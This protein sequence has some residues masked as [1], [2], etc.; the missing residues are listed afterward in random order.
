MLA[1]SNLTGQ[2]GGGR[3]IVGLA[4]SL[5][6]RLMGSWRRPLPWFE[7]TIGG[8]AAMLCKRLVTAARARSVALAGSSRLATA[9][10]PVIST[11]RTVGVSPSGFSAISAVGRTI[12]VGVATQP[13]GGVRN[14]TFSAARRLTRPSTTICWPSNSALRQSSRASAA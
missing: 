13:S 3:S 4:I 9:S 12:W 6:A 7:G 5:R 8:S 14:R 1:S 2:L 10:E 11:V